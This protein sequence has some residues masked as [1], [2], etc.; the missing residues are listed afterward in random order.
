MEPDSAMLNIDRLSEYPV[1]AVDVETTGLRWYEDRMFGVAVAVSDG[2]SIHAQYWDVRETPQIL[3]ALR[4][5]LPRCRKV[6]NHNIKFDA[7]FLRNEGVMLPDDGIECT[8]VRAALINEHER[9]FSLDALGLKYV[10]ERKEDIWQEMASL[11]GGLPTRDAQIRNL[12]RAPSSLVAKYATGDVILALR[13]WKW[14]QGEIDKQDLHK[15]WKLERALTPVLLEIERQGVRVNADLARRRAADLDAKV[16]ELQAGLKAIVGTEFNDSLANSPKQMR[17]LFNPERRGNDWYIGNVRLEKTDAGEPSIDKKS[18]MALAKAGDRRAQMIVDIRKYTKAAQF[19]KYHILEHE[20]NGRV[21]PNY[22]Q[23][24]GDSGYGTGTGRFSMNDPA[25]QQQPKRDEDVAE[26][27]RSCFLPERNHKWCCADWQQ[28]EFRWFAHYVKDESILR[29]YREKP[30]ADYHQMV[31]ELTGIPRK[32]RFAGDANAKQINLGLV[33]GMGQGKLAQEM[34]LPYTVQIRNGKEYLVPGEEARAVFEKYHA[35]IP[36]VKSL[37]DQ[38]S[39]IARSRGYVKTAMGRRIRFPGGQFVHK[40]GGLVF[41]GT[42]A[43]CMKQKMVE[44]HPLAR[45]YGYKI[46]LSMHDEL[47]F[48]LPAKEARHMMKEIKKVLET[49]DGVSCPIKCDVPI[50]SDVQ[51]GDNW[52]EACK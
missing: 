11:F 44:L 9:S 16:I 10:N 28:F 50:L 35:A 1:V 43:D 8:M 32:P 17:Q 30:D 15:V 20:H 22:N 51:L 31:A 39:S 6:V 24:R 4:H 7:H 49:F 5:H 3:E 23:T 19:L 33:F 46:L 37:L 41:Q 48:S 42:S 47:D 14:Q 34:G 52:W 18:L 25:L 13:L 27:V 45:K 12:H 29:M 26:L 38:A 21:Y 36:G 40:A 2:T